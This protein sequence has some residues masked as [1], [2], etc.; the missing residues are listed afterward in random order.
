M[1]QEEIIE[2]L[3]EQLY[4]NSKHLQEIANLKQEVKVLTETKNQL[5]KKIN[6]I[7]T[8][9]EETENILFAP[10]MEIA[11]TQQKIDFEQN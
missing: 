11:D 2:E 7:K 9:I 1:K 6:A 10:Y 3:R 5:I 8:S 4:V